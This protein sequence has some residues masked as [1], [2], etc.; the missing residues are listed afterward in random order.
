MEKII[1]FDQA[2]KLVL[3]KTDMLAPELVDV[4]KALGRVLA[5]DAQALVTLPM[6]PVSFRDG[7]ALNSEEAV[8]GKKLKIAGNIFSGNPLSES[9]KP[10]T[11][12]SIVTE[13]VL[14]EG[15]DA[16][17]EEESVKRVG[18]TIELQASVEPGTN[19]R[20]VGE[21]FSE[22]D[23]LEKKGALLS[24]RGIALLLAGGHFELEVIRRPRLWVIAAGDELRHPGSVIREGQE[25][26]SAGWLVA[27]LAEQLGCELARV[28]LVEDTVEALLEEI[29]VPESADLV[30]TVG[31]TGFGQKDIIEET[32]KQLGAEIIFQGVKMKPG[33]S[34]TFSKKARQVFYSL[35]GRIS[36]AEIAFELLARPGILK[37][38][39]KPELEHLM[40]HARVQKEIDSAPDQR[41][42][43]RGKMENKNGEV[44]VEPLHRKSWHKEMAEADGLIIIEE[45][46]GKLKPGDYVSFML[47]RNRLEAMVAKKLV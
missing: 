32:M 34:F 42:V 6:V 45:N 17:V 12:F 4:H 9:M 15:A 44:W 43:L 18:D 38:Q 7:Y 27:M 25:Y 14:P 40:V 3:S 24:E 1:G 26:P 39:G 37:M 22:G 33:H 21:E 28:I 11:A 2:K 13:A 46:R 31:G 23:L 8:A 30:I 5:N 19:V 20:Q 41:H 36:A 29:P 10:G 16:V 47:H 35:P